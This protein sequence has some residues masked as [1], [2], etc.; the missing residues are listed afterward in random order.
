MTDFHFWS[1]FKSSL[2]ENLVIVPESPL[3]K[4]LSINYD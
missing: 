2:I 4:Y 1:L 3:E